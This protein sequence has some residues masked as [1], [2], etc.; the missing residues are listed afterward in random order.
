MVRLRVLVFIG[1]GSAI[2]TPFVRPTFPKLNGGEAVTS[3]FIFCPLRERRAAYGKEVAS[4]PSPL[5]A[6]TF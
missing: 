1:V 4:E 6:L 2:L 5:S 3:P